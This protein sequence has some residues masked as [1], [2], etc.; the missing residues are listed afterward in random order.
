MVAELETAWRSNMANIGTFK[1]I[2]SEFH[3]EIVTLEQIPFILEHIHRE[4]NS[5]RTLLR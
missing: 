3:G 4:Q 2:N 5:L 1:K